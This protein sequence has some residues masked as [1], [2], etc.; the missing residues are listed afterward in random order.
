MRIWLDDIRKIPEDFDIHIKSYNDA[1]IYITGYKNKIK[2][3][4]FDHD[5]GTSKTGYDVAC[6]IER[7]AFIGKIKPFTWDIHSANPVGRK[8]I[9]MAMKKAEQYWEKKFGE[10]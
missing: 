10:K 7:L 4:S 2:H 1:K 3:I 5:L 8:N 6:L 9:E